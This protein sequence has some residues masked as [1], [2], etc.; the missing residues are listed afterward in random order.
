MKPKRDIQLNLQL[1][2]SL[3][4]NR[5]FSAGAKEQREKDIEQLVDLLETLED[6]HGIGEITADKI[7]EMFLSR[8][9]K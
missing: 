6:L 8:F 2:E 3:I 4:F 5:G 9:G 7:R 1:A